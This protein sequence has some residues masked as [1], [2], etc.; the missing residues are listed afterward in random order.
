MSSTIFGTDEKGFL[1]N[2]V[3]LKLDESIPFRIGISRMS[4]DHQWLQL[5]DS[6]RIKASASRW[7]PI[8]YAKTYHCTSI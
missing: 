1:S 7:M 8:E 6:E 2:G 3:E 5:A 4:K